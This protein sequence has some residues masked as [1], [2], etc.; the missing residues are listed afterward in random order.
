M[1]R[2]GATTWGWRSQ[3]ARGNKQGVL[4]GVEAEQDGMWGGGQQTSGRPGAFQNAQGYRSAVAGKTKRQDG[5]G[6]QEETSQLFFFFST[7]QVYLEC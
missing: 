5:G 2:F 3:E 4:E 6:K 1:T 7:S